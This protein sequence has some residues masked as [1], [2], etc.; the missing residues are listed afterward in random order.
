MHEAYCNPEGVFHIMP[1]ELHE[2][3]LSILKSQS[4]KIIKKQYGDKLSCLEITNK[5][6]DFQILVTLNK[7]N[8]ES[9]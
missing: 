8:A 4:I 3:K 7:W 9:R 5:Y 1:V 6:Q 2:Y